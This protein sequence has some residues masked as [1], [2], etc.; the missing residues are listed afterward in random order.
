M[1]FMKLILST[2][3]GE[4]TETIPFVPRLDIWYNANKYNDTLPSKYKNASLRDITDELGLGYHAVVPLFRD[5]ASENDDIDIGLGIYRFRAIPYH[6]ELHGVDRKV[7]RHSDGL[8]EVEYSTPKGK[9]KTGVLYDET[10]RKSGATLAFAKEHAVKN[11]QDFDALA[12]IFENAEV[13]PNYA[14]YKEFRESLVGDRGVAVGHCSLCASPMHFLIK[15]LMAFDNFYYT[16][17]EHPEEMELLAH[18]LSGYC[19]KIFDVAANSPAE[20]ILSGANYDR[21]ITTPDFF[22]KYITPVLKKQ[23]EKLHEKGK[24]L[25]THTDGENAGLLDLF[26]QSGFDIADSICP[27]PMTSLTLKET[28]ETFAGKITIWGGIPSNI[29]LENSMND[30]EFEKY[31]DMTLESIGK[32][33]HIIFSIADTTPPGAK[34]ERILKIAEKVK[35]FGP[36]RI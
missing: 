29:V 6:V 11:M 14:Y 30:Y 20:V 31:L 9:I 23:S 7:T 2:L 35:Q 25:L 21:S 18:R 5:Y 1:N 13:K 3:R 10:M 26:M 24:Y 16:Y 19:D 32:G 4:K 8:T 22:E 33:D 27:A 34:F 17:F 28:K 15:E 12:Y 36:V